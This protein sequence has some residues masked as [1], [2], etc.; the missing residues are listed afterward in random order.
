M[1]TKV[2]NKCLIEKTS[3]DL[4]KRTNTLDGY[5]PLC[6]ICYN[7]YKNDYYKKNSTKIKE[8]QRK[9]K[10]KNPNYIVSYREKNREKLLN[11]MKDYYYNNSEKLKDDMKKY[12]RERNRTDSLFNLKSTLRTRIYKFL[13]V[14]NIKK[15]SKTFEIIGC[16]PNEL[17]EH[18][19]RQFTDNMG[20][21][22]RSLWHI[23]HIIPL[24]SAKSEDEIYKLCHYSNLQP[25]WAQD[26][27]KKSNKILIKNII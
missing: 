20:W 17:K 24:S 15:N 16:S 23:D 19:E 7:K 27:L 1:I 18:L 13:L 11:Q 8:T 10:D 9:S 4:V 26:N 22:N 3:D 25:L 21:D 12:Q 14:K 2:C 5:S 6:K